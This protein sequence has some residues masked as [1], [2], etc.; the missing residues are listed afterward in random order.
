[1]SSEYQEGID[2]IMLLNNNLGRTRQLQGFQWQLTQNGP[3]NAPVHHAIALRFSQWAS[4]RSQRG[5]VEE[6]RQETGRVLCL[7]T[8]Q[9]SLRVAAIR[10]ETV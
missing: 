10:V 5:K 1:M 2:Y 8:P 9:T 4:D 6:R 7:G 3:P